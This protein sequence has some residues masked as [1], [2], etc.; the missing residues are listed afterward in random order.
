M[1]MYS[2]GMNSLFNS[3]ALV[4]HLSPKKEIYAGERV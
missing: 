4:N 2:L 3:F 1:N